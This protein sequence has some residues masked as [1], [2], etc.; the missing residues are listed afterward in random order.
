MNNIKYFVQTYY[1]LPNSKYLLD[2]I[3]ALPIIIGKMM[4][5]KPKNRVVTDLMNSITILSIDI[6]LV[7]NY[8]DIYQEMVF[9]HW[10][11][12]Y[13]PKPKHR[14]RNEDGSV[15]TPTQI[16]EMVAERRERLYQN[17]Q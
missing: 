16:Q 2:K 12:V 11:T 6:D 9:W 10:N 1:Q 17:M 5:K 4:A 8:R 14:Y 7:P 15:K 13:V 3:E